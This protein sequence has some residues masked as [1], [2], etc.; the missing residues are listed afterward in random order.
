MAF[1]LS[2]AAK[3]EDSVIRRRHMIGDGSSNRERLFAVKH[4]CC[5]ISVPACSHLSTEAVRARLAVADHPLAQRLNDITA[6][7]CDVCHSADG[8]W[9]C[10]DC[11]FAGCSRNA[12]HPE[13]GGGHALMHYYHQ[14]CTGS[15]VFD[16]ITKHCHCYACDDYVTDDLVLHPE[17]DEI[18]LKLADVTLPENLPK[19]VDAESLADLPTST[20]GGGGRY[21]SG[22]GRTGLTNLRNTCFMNAGIQVL[23]SLGGFR[24]F[25]RDFL[26]YAGDFRQ[27]SVKLERRQTAG[28]LGHKAMAEARARPDRDAQLELVKAMHSVMRVLHSGKYE[29]GAARS[30]LP[31]PTT[32]SRLRWPSMASHRPPTDLPPTSHRPSND[33]PPTFHRPSTDLPRPSVRYDSFAPRSLVLRAWKHWAFEEGQQGDAAEFLTW[34]LDTFE[35]ELEGRSVTPSAPSFAGGCVVRDS[36]AVQVRSPSELPC[37][38]LRPPALTS[39]RFRLPSSS[40]LPPCRPS[41]RSAATRARRARSA[42][43][44][45]SARSDSPSPTRA[46]PAA[47]ARSRA[48]SQTTSSRR[49]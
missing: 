17:L 38:S 18:R 15:V 29:S 16:V 49:S 21:V 43:R 33:L 30:N 8:V 12:S 3:A 47:S 32:R 41:T 7:R 45:R 39:L 31:W 26:K 10:L 20:K 27:G 24:S 2:A 34:L 4:M 14:G 28:P 36:F 35:D 19:E 44:T 42:G 40:D 48:A 23:A 46:T 13:L 9:V 5:G 22:A 25:F 37:I 6:W 1:Q 11:G